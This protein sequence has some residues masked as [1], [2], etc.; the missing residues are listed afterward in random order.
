M[1]PKFCL[2]SEISLDDS[3]A[4]GLAKSRASRS[5]L[6]PEHLPRILAQ[7]AQG[8]TLEEIGRRWGVKRAAV[9]SFLERH[10]KGGQ[11]A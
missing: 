10:N 2:A 11:Q 6:Q 7:R 4:R 1:N 3:R 9:E 8:L 5:R